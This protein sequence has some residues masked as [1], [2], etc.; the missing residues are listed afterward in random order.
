MQL[1]KNKTAIITGASR[2]I[3]KGIALGFAMQGCDVAFTYSRSE[4]EALSLEKRLTDIGIKAKA[5]KSNAASFNACQ[6]LI[7]NVL[8]DFSNIDMLINNAGITK[9]GL[10][11]RMN[12]EN[13]DKV[14]EVNLKSIFNMTKSVLPTFLRQKKGIL[15]HMG[16]VVGI[17]GNAGQT[18]LC[19]I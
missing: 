5:Y 2:G 3:G 7:V 13:F 4:A 9:D 8:E 16:S 6:E 19:C 1:L 17:K 10:L 12:E 15:I 14:I 18:N 11:L